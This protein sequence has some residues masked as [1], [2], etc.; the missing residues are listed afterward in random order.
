MRWTREQQAKRNAAQRRFTAAHPERVRNSKLKNLYGIS[1]D[2]YDALLAIQ[3][4]VC[5]LCQRPPVPGRRLAVDH[6][7]ETGAVR[8][9]LCIACNV[10]VGVMEKM[11]QNGL[12]ERYLGYLAVPVLA[13]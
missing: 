11:M 9:L 1:S 7:H 13:W 6:N 8:A 4:G 2:D 12:M 10:R 5:G 3:G